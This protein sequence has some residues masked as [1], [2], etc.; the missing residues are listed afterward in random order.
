MSKF[1]AEQPVNSISNI[2]SRLAGYSKAGEYPM[3]KLNTLSK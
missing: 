3:S 1:K 2:P